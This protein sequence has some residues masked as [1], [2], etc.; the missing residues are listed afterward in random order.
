[1]SDC[2][3]VSD[4]TT[5]DFCLTGLC[6]GA[7]P[8]TP[9][10]ATGNPSP[11]PSAGHLPAI[12]TQAA[13]PADRPAPLDLARPL[14]GR[15]A[16]RA[17]LRATTHGP[18]VATEALPGVLATVESRRQAWPTHGRQRHPSVDQAHVTS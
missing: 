15:M 18:R 8:L 6:R 7:V 4:D 13:H 17:R 3:E 11:P 9:V 10:D 14:V 12:G 1:M 2:D 5:C 16:G